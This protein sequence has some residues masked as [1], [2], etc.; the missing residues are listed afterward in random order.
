VVIGKKYRAHL[1]A[2]EIAVNSGMRP[3]EPYGF[4]WD[5]V[6]LCRFVTI[7][8]EQEWQDATYPS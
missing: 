2:F 4:T 6:D 1:P 7:P 5:R 3:S 8:E